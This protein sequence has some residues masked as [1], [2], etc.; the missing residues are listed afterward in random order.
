M[1]VVSMQGVEVQ[2]EIGNTG[3]DRVLIQSEIELRTPMVTSWEPRSACHEEKE[4]EEKMVGRV[5]RLCSVTSFGSENFLIMGPPSCVMGTAP[6]IVIFGVTTNNV[7]VYRRRSN[8]RC[9]RATP[10]GS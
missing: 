9:I 2:W 8:A 7:A 5:P 4:K 10:H 6:K 1:C 3:L